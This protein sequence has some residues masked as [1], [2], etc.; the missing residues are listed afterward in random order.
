MPPP[1]S[2]SS[3][4]AEGRSLRSSATGST[5][6]PERGRRGPANVIFMAKP[7]SSRSGRG[8]KP[9]PESTADAVEPEARRDE[10][11]REAGAAGEREGTRPDEGDVVVAGEK[12]ALRRIER[13]QDKGGPEPVGRGLGGEVAPLGREGD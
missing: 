11:G 3:A 12:V 2:S 5:T 4:A 13:A 10:D 1:L 6:V 9:P 7:S 8:G